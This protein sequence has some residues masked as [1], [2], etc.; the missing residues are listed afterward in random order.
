MALF[1]NVRDVDVDEVARN[2][3]TYGE[4]STVT[5][6]Y[7]ASFSGAVIATDSGATFRLNTGSRHAG[8]AKAAIDLIRDLLADQNI[9]LRGSW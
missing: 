2:E 6:Y 4:Y 5:A 8:T 3:D 9:E 7:S 1:A